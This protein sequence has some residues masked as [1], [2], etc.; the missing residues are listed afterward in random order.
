MKKEEHEIQS[1]CVRWFRLQYPKLVLFAIPNGAM[2]NGTA[3]Q[4]ARAWKRLER[5]GAKPGVADLFLA[6]P[7][8]DSA[9]LFIEMKTSRGRQSPTQ[10]QFEMD[11]MKAGYGYAMPRSL[12]EFIKVVKRYLETGEY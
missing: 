3:Q 6:Q 9:G 10:F 1:A 8:G 12:D 4:R 11:A 2:L 5:E 7:S